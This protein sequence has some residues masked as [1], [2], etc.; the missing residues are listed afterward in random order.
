MRKCEMS[1]FLET[2]DYM[3]VFVYIVTLAT[4]NQSDKAPQLWSTFSTLISYDCTYSIGH[5]V[6]LLQICIC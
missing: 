5:D 1:C 6:C 3:S 2:N 4:P